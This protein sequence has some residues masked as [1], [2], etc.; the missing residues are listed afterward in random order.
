M[1]ADDLVR[2]QEG[3]GKGPKL[4][5]AKDVDDDHYSSAYDYLS[6][7]WL[8]QQA[9]PA[10]QALR[11]ADL[12]HYQPGDL[13]RAAGLEPKPLNDALV[14]R[15]LIRAIRD[16]QL[17]PILCINLPQGIVIADGLHRTSLAYALAPWHKMPLKL[18]PSAKESFRGPTR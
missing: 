7:H 17:Q 12:Q 3:D 5:W 2:L 6:L 18:A 8:P 16:G 15:E 11:D 9:G 1:S 4:P 10:V 13:L 14:R